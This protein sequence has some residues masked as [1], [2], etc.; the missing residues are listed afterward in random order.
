MLLSG[1]QNIDLSSDK[2]D[3]SLTLSNLSNRGHYHHNSSIISTAGNLLADMTTYP[4]SFSCLHSSKG[5][6]ILWFHHLFSPPWPPSH[7]CPIPLSFLFTKIQFC[8]QPWTL[9]YVHHQ[10]PSPLLTLSHSL[11]KATSHSLGK[12]TSQVQSNSLTTPH[13]HQ[14]AKHGWK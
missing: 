7:P 12:A 11:G 14:A 5:P 8:S 2:P 6:M 13:L 3:L 1:I 9:P 10:S 4:N